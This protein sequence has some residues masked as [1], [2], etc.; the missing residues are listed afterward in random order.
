M[1]SDKVMAFAT[2]IMQRSWRILLI[3]FVFITVTFSV[4]AEVVERLDYEDYRVDIRQGESLLNALNR[5]SS[6]RQNNKVFHGLTRWNVD[7]NYRW[8]Q[9]TGSCRITE[10]SVK[11]VGKITLPVLYG[12]DQPQRTR[13]DA[14]RVKL[15]THELGHYYFA[16]QAARAI[17]TRL[18]S[19]PE[20]SDCSR[21]ERQ[22]NQEAQN[23]LD[24]FIQQERQYDIDTGHGRTQGAILQPDR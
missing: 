2:K 9:K 12:A 11:A 16:L 5:S 4:Q 1:P 13:F 24:H 17:D 8:W 14:Y 23:I 3:P 20:F 22:A 21:L 10:T 6:I 15:E 19:L 18:K 7:W